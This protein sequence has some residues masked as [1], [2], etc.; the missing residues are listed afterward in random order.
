MAGRQRG[1]CWSIC[2]LNN[3]SVLAED[4]ACRLLECKVEST[5]VKFIGGE[6]LLGSLYLRRGDFGSAQKYFQQSLT[7]LADSDHTYAEA[8][9][10]GSACGLGDVALRDSRP[11]TAL[12]HYRKAWQIVQEFPTIM[13]HERHSARALASLATA[14]AAV[15]QQDRAKKL[16]AQ[17]M[18][19]LQRSCRFE[20]SAAGANL[21]EL[22]Y[23]FAV[24]YLR[25]GN[26]DRGIEHLER[27][28]NAGWHDADWLELDP[29]LSE[30]RSHP[31]LVALL[32]KIRSL[33]PVFERQPID[34]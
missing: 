29:E 17:A 1:S 14:Y 11:D 9:K 6:N 25:L 13:A 26:Y 23:T 21:A 30:L 33:P 5:T 24:A 8:M 22:H 4:F 27:A 34:R 7:T 20:T 16:L 28:F 15:Q 12:V 2:L 3:E 19:L 32:G 10:A 18:P 31:S